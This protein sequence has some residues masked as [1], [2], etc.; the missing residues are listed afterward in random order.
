MKITARTIMRRTLQKQ[1]GKLHEHRMKKGR[2]TQQ[3]LEEVGDTG[4]MKHAVEESEVLAAMN[5]Q[6]EAHP[7]VLRKFSIGLEQKSSLS[8]EAPSDSIV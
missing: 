2:A 7:G 1:Q 3:A 6:L 8:P 4:G 5:V